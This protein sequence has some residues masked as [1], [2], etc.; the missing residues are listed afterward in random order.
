MNSNTDWENFS[1]QAEVAAMA[2]HVMRTWEGLTRDQAFLAMR[3]GFEGAWHTV[4]DYF[5]YFTVNEQLSSPTRLASQRRA[6]MRTLGYTLEQQL[7]D[8]VSVVLY[9][10]DTATSDFPRPPDFDEVFGKLY[11]GTLKVMGKE[12]TKARPLGWLTRKPD[13]QALHSARATNMA[14]FQGTAISHPCVPHFV[15]ATGIENVKYMSSEKD[16]KPFETLLGA[17]YS[18]GYLLRV[19]YNNELMGRALSTLDIHQKCAN[20][21]DTVTLDAV[22]PLKR[23]LEEKAQTDAEVEQA[24]KLI[25]WEYPQQ[26]STPSLG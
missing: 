24:L 20:L 6:L 13:L 8:S 16:R 2:D 25:V 12:V 4:G 19:K 18:H 1:T 10:V 17:A 23:L 22:E 11:R 14:N 3:A 7:D 21:G 15:V 26:G 9:A 5:E